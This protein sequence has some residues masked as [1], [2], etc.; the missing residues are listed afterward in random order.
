MSAD[1]RVTFW[2]DIPVGASLN[3]KVSGDRALVTALVADATSSQAVDNNA[4]RAGYTCRLSK[5]GNTWA[6]VWFEKA[7]VLPATVTIEEAVVDAAG[8]PQRNSSYQTTLTKDA[9]DDV[10]IVKVRVG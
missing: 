10:A 3:L 7:D 4:L 2:Q 8:E 5:A 9:S 6:H 1:S